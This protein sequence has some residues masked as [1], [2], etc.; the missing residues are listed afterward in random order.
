MRQAIGRR[1]V[2]NPYLWAF[3]I[4]SWSS[5]AA[6][7]VLQRFLSSV[8][9]WRLAKHPEEA[10]EQLVTIGNIKGI[11]TVPKHYTSRII[12]TRRWSPRRTVGSGRKDLCAHA[13]GAQ[14]TIAGTAKNLLP[15]LSLTLESSLCSGNASAAA[16]PQAEISHC[17][18]LHSGEHLLDA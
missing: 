4:S 12:W 11:R 17:D 9:S 13:L 15:R 3:L 1:T 2:I 6:V 5:I 18:I 10:V 14:G 8:H 7:A 16:R